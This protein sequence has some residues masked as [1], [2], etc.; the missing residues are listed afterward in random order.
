MFMHRNLRI[1]HAIDMSRYNVKSDHKDDV[2]PRGIM[3]ITMLALFILYILVITIEGIALCCF[4]KICAFVNITK[5]LST[6]S[7]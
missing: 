7:Y 6:Q 3:F 4:E 2:F 1:L 5:K